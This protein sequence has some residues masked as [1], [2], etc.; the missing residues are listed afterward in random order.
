MPSRSANRSP[1]L[2]ARLRPWAPAVV[3]GLAL[4]LTGCGGGTQRIRISG[5]VTFQGKPVPYGNLVFEPD[6]SK[7]N[8][9]PQGY[10]KIQDGRYDT[11]NAGTGALPRPPGRLPGGLPRAGQ[12]YDPEGP[13]GVQVPHDRG[14]AG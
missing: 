5:Q 13:V 1:P 2:I 10:A 8:R 9:G 11:N 4:A 6:Q 12:R 7:G 3:T 14:R